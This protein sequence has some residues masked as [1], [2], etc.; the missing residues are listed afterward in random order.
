[1]YNLAHDRWIV[2][3][4]VTPLGVRTHL[5]VIYSHNN[6]LCVCSVSSGL[7]RLGDIS[8]AERGRTEDS[9]G[10]V[11]STKGTIGESL[12]SFHC[13]HHIVSCS[14]H[15]RVDVADCFPR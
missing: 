15:G 5:N 9:R 2:A 7:S 1:M 6:D 11:P 10:E 4:V 13:I 12:A 3:I 8:P 14:K